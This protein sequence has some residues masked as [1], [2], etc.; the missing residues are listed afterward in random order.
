MNPRRAADLFGRQL[1]QIFGC[2]CSEAKLQEIKR[3]IAIT[4]KGIIGS[5]NGYTLLHAFSE[6]GIEPP[7]RLLWEK[8]ADIEAKD[9]NGETALHLAARYGHSKI[10]R[11]LLSSGCKVD[12]ISKQGTALLIAVRG[13]AVDAVRILLGR[14]ASMESKDEFGN[15]LRVFLVTTGLSDCSSNKAQILN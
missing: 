10:V 2:G 11:L 4:E 7:V 3:N 8:G 12:L 9:S 1:L 14:G 5:G 15:T 13:G 6:F